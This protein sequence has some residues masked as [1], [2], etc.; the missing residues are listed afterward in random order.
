MLSMKGYCWIT[1]M[2]DGFRYDKSTTYQE[3]VETGH[4][5]KAKKI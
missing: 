4:M 5:I 1:G 2:K 3:R